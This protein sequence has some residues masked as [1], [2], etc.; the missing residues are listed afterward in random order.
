M[1]RLT[2]VQIEHLKHRLAVK[3]GELLHAAPA[4][5]QRMSVQKE[6]YALQKKESAQ[7]IINASADEVKAAVLTC[8]K[9][10]HCCTI[11]GQLRKSATWKAGPGKAIKLLK[12]R[13][14]TL[15]KRVAR[16]RTKLQDQTTQIIDSAIFSGTGDEVLALIEAFMAK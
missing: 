4:Y 15:D 16:D 11:E 8:R 3:S 5:Q 6:F 7:L 13:I 2:K 1:A 9:A 12:K 14:A 10:Y